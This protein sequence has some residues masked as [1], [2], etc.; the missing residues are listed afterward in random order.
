MHEKIETLNIKR[1]SKSGQ[2]DLAIYEKKS[3]LGKAK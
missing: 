3:K 1:T 2:F